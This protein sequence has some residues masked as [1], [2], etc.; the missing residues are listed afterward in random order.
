MQPQKKLL[1]IFALALFFRRSLGCNKGG[2]QIK[3][4][5]GLGGG[6]GGGGG[7]SGNQVRKKKPDATA[8]DCKYAFLFAKREQ[9]LRAEEEPPQVEAEVLLPPVE[10]VG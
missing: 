9:L 8:L 10:E 1:F 7:G 6:G 5:T 4:P 2:V 3:P